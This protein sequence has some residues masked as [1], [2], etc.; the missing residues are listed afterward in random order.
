M[1]ATSYRTQEIESSFRALDGFAEYYRNEIAPWL[2]EQVD[3]QKQGKRHARLV[4]IAGGIG[5]PFVIAAFW[6]LADAMFSS[7]ESR[8]SLM[9]LIVMIKV[10]PPALYA[11]WVAVQAMRNLDDLQ[12]EIKSFILRKTCGFLNFSYSA[13]AGGFPFYRF[14]DTRLLPA[15]DRAE[16]EDNISGSHDGVDFNLVEAKLEQI[17]WERGFRIRYEEIYHG[18]L[19]EFTFPKPFAGRT[20]VAEE[21]GSICN[22]LTGLGVAGERVRLE[23]PRFEKRFEAWSTDQVEARYLL[24]PA[25]MERMMDLADAFGDGLP[26][27]C[28][29]DNRLLVSLPVKHNHFEAGDAFAPTTDLARVEDLLR[30]LR[31]VIDVIEILKLNI[32]TRA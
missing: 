4:G 13:T 2:A 3:R 17:K 22:Y 1:T 5:L 7:P 12:K 26:E 20:L 30:E 11:F 10:I 16:I 18:I 25:F 9:T 32:R 8:E 14:D 19:I 24:T 15:H 27:F 29:T 28:F 6:F 23:D 21:Q 31:K